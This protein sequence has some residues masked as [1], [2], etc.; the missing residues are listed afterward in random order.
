MRASVL[1]EL[2]DLKAAANVRSRPPLVLVDVMAW[3]DGDR[4]AYW[5][6]EAAGDGETVDDL[7]ER[8]TGQRPEPSEPGAIGMVVVSLGEASRADWLRT[9]HLDD[10]ALE[11]EQERRVR[12]EDHAA[13]DAQER[14]LIEEAARRSVPDLPPGV[15]GYDR[16][17]YPI[18]HGDPRAVGVWKPG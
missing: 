11:A 18:P 15:W 3:P 5:A 1:K 16:A 7:I 10:D 4:D 9:R 6:A 12:D 8:Q 14:A 17:G 13:R 2:A